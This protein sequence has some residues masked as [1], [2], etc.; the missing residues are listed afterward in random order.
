M[1]RSKLTVRSI[2]HL[3]APDPSGKQRLH[4]DVELKGFG[5]LCSGST[6]AKTFVVQRDLSGGRTRRVTIGPVNVLGLDQARER[7]QVILADFYQGVDPKASRRGAAATLQQTLNDYLVARKSLRDNTRRDYNSIGKHL[8]DWMDRPLRSI[9]PEDVESKHRSI[10]SS[11]GAGGRYSGEATA[12]AAMRAF[13]LLYNFALE[14]DPGMPPNP[15]RRSK[16]QWFAVPRRE[17]YVTAAQLPAFYAAVQSLPNPIARDYLLLLLFTG[18][19]RG[20]AA[21]LSW[22]DVDMVEKVI[23]LPAT[24][25]KAGRKLDLP[26]SDVVLDL[27]KERS[28]LGREKFVFPSNGKSGY[29]SDPKFPLNAVALA[30]GVA[31]SAHDL[32][33]TF[34]TVAEIGRHFSPGTQGAGQ[35]FHRQGRHFRL[36][37]DDR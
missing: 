8:S 28:R 25:T 12:N 24:R 14:R 6:D 16:R 11:I 20:E 19:R 33:R 21:S 30:S 34:V 1:S 10:A 22:T 36:C 3:R 35:S 37:A 31:V 5:V 29:I 32:R 17:R 7:A 27:F 15:V 26:M 13:R 2:S 4:W 9:T 23:R 18:L